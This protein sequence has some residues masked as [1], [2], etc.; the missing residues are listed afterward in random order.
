MKLLTPSAPRVTGATRVCI[1]GAVF[2][3]MTIGVSATAAAVASPVGTGW[4]I[5]VL[6]QPTDF[7]SSTN[8]GCQENK[9]SRLCDSYAVL[10]TNMGGMTEAPVTITDA[11]P[12]GLTAVGSGGN[13]PIHLLDLGTDAGSTCTVVPLQCIDPSAVAPGD[14]LLM[15]INVTVTEGLSGNVMNTATVSSAGRP[16]ADAS[17]LT[18][19]SPEQAPFGIANFD[20]GAFEAAGNPLDQAGARPTNIFSTLT[21]STYDNVANRGQNQGAYYPVEEPRDVVVDLPPGLVGNPEATPK[22]PVSALENGSGGTNCPAAS[23]VGSVVFQANPGNFRSSDKGATDSTT[24]LY[25]LVPEAGFPAEFGFTYIDKAVVLYS[26]L[27]HTDAGY[28]SRV[29]S[30]GAPE[31]QTDGVSLLFFGNPAQRDGGAATSTAF[32]TNP[33]NCSGGPLTARARVDSWENPGHWVTAESTVYPKITECNMLQFQPNLSIIPDTTQ[34]DEPSGYEV[35]IEAPQNENSLTPGTPELKNVSLTLPP[36][37]SASPSAADGLQGCYP[38]GPNGFN[39]GGKFNAEGVSDSDPEATVAGPDGLPHLAPGHCPGASR[40]GTVEITTPVLPQPLEGS[41]FLAAPRCG[42]E[43]QPSCTPADAANGNLFGVYLEAQGQGVVVKLSGRVSASPT[44]GQ[45]TTTFT[46]NPQLPFSDLKIRLKGGPRALLANPQTC[47]LARATSDMT[48]W[49]SPITPDAT[50]L[51]SVGFDWDGAGGACPASLPFAPGFLAGTSIPAAGG[52]SPFT[53]TLSRGDREQDP[54]RLQLRMPAG[55]LGMLSKVP[56]CQEPLAAQGRAPPASQIGHVTVGAGSGPDQLF[57]PQTGRRRSGV[58]DGAVQGR[59]V[60][61]FVLV[62]AEAGPLNLGPSLFAQ[63][64]TSTRTPR[65]DRHQRPAAADPARHTAGVRTVN[66]SVDRSEFSFNPTDC[67]PLS[68]TGDDHLALG[69]W[70]R[71]LSVSGGQLC[72]AAVPAEVHGLH[73]RA[74]RQEHGASLDV[75]VAS[76]AGQANIGRVARSLPKQLPARFTTLQKA[77]IEATFAANPPPARRP[78]SWVWPTPHASARRAAHRSRVPRLARRCG[79]P[80]PRGDPAGRGHRA[81]PRSA[82]PH[83]EEHHH[84]HVRL[85]ARRAD[86]ELRT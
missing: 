3:M 65:R 56:L 29:E 40:V 28:V 54:S 49:S 80:R 21:L 67:D 19:I 58:S 64:S 7:S 41:L 17:V 73:C 9:G 70:Q 74:H 59:A 84:Q 13:L 62:H 4:S 83:Q 79:V 35:N 72:G 71:L 36:G 37:V 2:V 86:H 44:T 50:P 24:A 66:V 82:T 25:S 20:V 60:W 69:A 76:G 14:T 16:L 43:G 57:L 51:A 5:R 15:T 78:R 39:E 34:A 10:V 48:P 27:A 52:F 63:P 85:S 38:T 30:P 68:V 1:L 47:G 61:P 18:T 22:C 26:T 42:G 12:I 6:A 81:R 31:F 8:T 55:L 53:L 33:V 77:C 32:F 45:L 75:K 23:R 46:E 11:L